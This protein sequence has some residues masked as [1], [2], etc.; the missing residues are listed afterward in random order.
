[1]TDSSQ[2]GHEETLYQ[3]PDLG[4]GPL[5]GT[6]SGVETSERSER[7]RSPDGGETRSEAERRGGRPAP[8]GKERP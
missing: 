8:L 6:R 2:H 3:A 5:V 1:M 4:L 7:R